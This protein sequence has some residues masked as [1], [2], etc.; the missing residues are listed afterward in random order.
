MIKWLLAAV[1]LLAQSVGAGTGTGGPTTDLLLDLQPLATPQAAARVNVALQAGHWKTEELPAPLAHL[2][3]STGTY[4]GG[5]TEAQLNLDIAQRAAKL[6][7]NRGLTVEILP[8]TVPT[9]YTADLFISLHAD[10]TAGSAPRG[11]KVSTRWRSEVAALDALLV[12]SLDKAY[13]R[14][15]GLPKDSNITRNM[16]GYYAYSTYRGEEYRLGETTPAAILEMGFM[17]NPTDRAFMFNRADT[18]AEA[19]VAGITS[20]F[21]RE[22]EGKRLQAEAERQAAASRYGRSAVAIT[23]GVNVRSGAGTSTRKLGTAELGEA[24][25]LLEQGRRPATNN[26]YNVRWGEASAYISRDFVVIQQ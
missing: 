21:A 23:E 17:T 12:E 22:A 19:I 24:F 9:G 16:R 3:T 7:R 13:G 5:R 10:G 2:R 6:L 4:G 14:V 20:Y 26:F 18:V 8:A 25:P 11:Y 1:I 15:T